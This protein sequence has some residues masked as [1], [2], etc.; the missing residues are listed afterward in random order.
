MILTVTLNPSVDTLYKMDK[1]IIDSVNRTS[2]IKVLGGKGV[3]AA[4]VSSL[5]G[6]KTIVTG[7]LGGYNGTFFKDNLNKLV[8]NNPMKNEF[9]T[10]SEETRNCITIMHDK[11]KQTEIN[12]FGPKIKDAEIVQLLSKIKNLIE[13]NPI[14]VIVLSGSIPRGVPNDIYYKLISFIHSISHEIKVIL[15]TSQDVLKNTIN[16]CVIND[17]FPYAVKPNIEELKDISTIK[18]DNVPNLI[19]NCNMEKIPVVIVSEGANGCFAKIKNNCYTAKVKKIVAINPTGSGDSTVGALAFAFEQKFNDES[20]LRSAM[21][22]G[23]SNAL[24][25]NIGYISLTNYKKY[26]KEV[27]IQKIN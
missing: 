16:L 2:P 15:D 19:N 12:E 17:V 20:T 10:C 7:F 11:E 6:S 23:E 21:A 22:A 13:T 14:T 18:T 25:E 5:L 1:L 8:P 3:N 24:E 4:R 27:H 9:V 26:Y